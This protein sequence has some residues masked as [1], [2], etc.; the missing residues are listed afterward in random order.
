MNIPHWLSQPHPEIATP[1]NT[2]GSPNPPS[3]KITLNTVPKISRF[4]STKINPPEC[5]SSPSLQS[6]RLI[7][8]S[9]KISPQPPQKLL[10]PLNVKALPP[11][12]DID[13]TLNSIQPVDHNTTTSE[14]Y[15][16]IASDGELYLDTTD[17]FESASEGD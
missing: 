11:I 7:G 13:G 9:P 14:E 8:S 10:Q 12:T 4:P 5:G 1:L 15:V 6:P 3:P 2:I 16:D 17:I